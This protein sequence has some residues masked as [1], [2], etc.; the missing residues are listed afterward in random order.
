MDGVVKITN[1]IVGGLA[2]Y[3]T[4]PDGTYYYMAHLS[5]LADGVVEGLAVKTG[6]IVGFVGDSGDAKGGPPHVHFEVHPQGGPAVD[7]KAILDGWLAEALAHVPALI[8][9]RSADVPQAVV[10]TSV[11]RRLSDGGSGFGAPA[12][13]ARSQL[14]WAS[15][16]NPAGG[17]L[18]LA[19]AE[20]AG[21]ARR[22]DW[23][24]VTRVQQ[25]KALR[26]QADLARAHRVIDPLVPPAARGLFS[27]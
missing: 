14:L 8:G 9:E 12:G 24:E 6:D 4:T 17:P 3:V 7:P 23:D 26:W 21:A 1:G 15:S 16:A 18:R 22:L 19:E 20:A 27:G 13:P 25:A 2:V 5:G 10:A 11:T